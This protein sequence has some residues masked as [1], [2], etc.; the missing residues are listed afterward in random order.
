[1]T[2]VQ[3]CALPISLGS[4]FTNKKQRVKLAPRVQQAASLVGAGAVLVGLVQKVKGERRLYL[5]WVNADDDETPVDESISLAGSKDERRRAIEGA[6]AGTLERFSPKPVEAKEDAAPPP[7]PPTEEEKPARQRHEAGSAIV[8]IEVG[9]EGGARFFDY[10]D[11]ITQN[12]RSYDV[13]PAPLVA[14]SVELYPAA[15]TTIPG[16]RDIGLVGGYARA[17]ALQSKTKNGAPIDTLYQRWYGALKYRIPLSRPTGPVIGMLAGVQGQTF[18]VD[19]TGTL[20]DQV[21]NVDYLSIRGGLSGWIPLGSVALFF[22][23]DWLEPLNTGPVYERFTGAKVH[24]VE[25]ALGLAVRWSSGFQLRLTGEYT[26]FFSDFD[27][28]PGDV[29]IAGGALDQLLGLRLSAA[30]MD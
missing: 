18:S 21:A 25:G 14:A 8:S 29:H 30:Y 22:G 24:G 5:V 7:P 13:L 11:R 12:L 28:V 26:R 9:F 4:A 19:A 1:V 3:T 20:A 10:S 2:G 16:L 6:L 15:M 17:F 27:P 23:A